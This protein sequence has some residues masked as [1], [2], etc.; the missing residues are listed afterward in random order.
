MFSVVA[1]TRNSS[2]THRSRRTTREKWTVTWFWS[3]T[4]ACLSVV[5]VR[6]RR[7][8]N[9][10]IGS[11]S[12]DVF[13]RRT[14]AGSEVFSLLTCLDD[15]KFV[16]LSF[17]TVIEAIWLKICAKP[18]SK[19]EKRPLPVDVRRSKTL[20]LKLPNECSRTGRENERLTEKLSD[21]C[22]KSALE[23]PLIIHLVVA[24]AGLPHRTD[25]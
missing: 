3:C 25:F 2:T 14:S 19:N 6:S 1:T 7:I 22:L 18:P 9:S 16:L 5:V 21:F 23:L 12:S 11:L 15:I 20:L 13:E 17:F 8:L 4:V 10:L 24:Y